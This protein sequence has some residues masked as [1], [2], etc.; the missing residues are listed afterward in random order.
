MITEIR[1]R[2]PTDSQ[3]ELERFT[4]FDH[5]VDLADLKPEEIAQQVGESLESFARIVGPK[6][7]LRI[8]VRS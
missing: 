7:W 4:T 8:E 2:L 1:Y 3:W 5:G 6:L